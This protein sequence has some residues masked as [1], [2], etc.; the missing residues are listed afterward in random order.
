MFSGEFGN[1]W[2]NVNTLRRQQSYLRWTHLKQIKEWASVALDST[3]QVINSRKRQAS[4]AT[5]LQR[6]H[7]HK[8]PEEDDLEKPVSGIRYTVR[9][10]AGVP[11]FVTLLLISCIKAL[12][13]RNER[14]FLY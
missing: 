7:Q 5:S 12:M 13:S 8:C 9:P 14:D 3:P 11:S 6:E 10:S 4:E 1:G 2:R